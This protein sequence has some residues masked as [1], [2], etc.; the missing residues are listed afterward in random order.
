MLS[1][2]EFAARYRVAYATV[3]R[4]CKC[5]KLPAVRIGAAWR[6][7]EAAYING[8]TPPEKEKAR[9][10]AGA[11]CFKRHRAARAKSDFLRALAEL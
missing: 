2:K 7:D 3:W 5:G 8:Y 11:A 4:Q 6:I 1:I 10:E 9:Q